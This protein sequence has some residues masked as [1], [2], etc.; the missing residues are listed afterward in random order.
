MM[1]GCLT[2]PRPSGK[3][4]LSI[5]TSKDWANHCIKTNTNQDSSCFYSNVHFPMSLA[6]KEYHWT[7][8]TPW[9]NQDKHCCPI[10]HLRNPSFRNIKGLV[11]G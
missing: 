3:S 2:A 5:K 9:G 10:V 7:V 6:M 8:K 11:Q 4:S 1:R